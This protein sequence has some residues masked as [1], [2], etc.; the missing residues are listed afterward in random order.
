MTTIQ[1]TIRHTIVATAVLA[2]LI[3]SPVAANAAPAGTA[4][5]ANCV[6]DLTGRTTTRCFDTLTEAMTLA[7]GGRFTDAPATAAEAVADRTFASKVDAANSSRTSLVN[8]IVI[9]IEY[10]LR[11]LDETGGTLVWRGDKE[12]SNRTTDVDYSINSYPVSAPS[13]ENRISSFETFANCF[14]KHY[15]TTNQ[16]GASVGF[17]GTRNYIGVAMDNRTSSQEWS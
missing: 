3:A 10:D 9:S 12:C 13:W 4:A 17:T 11:D 16:N 15:E 2:A 14:A 5:K 8:D 1:P 6:A 7:T